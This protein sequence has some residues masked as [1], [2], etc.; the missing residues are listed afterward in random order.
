[1]TPRKST[2]R[3]FTA[4]LLFTFVL[5]ACGGESPE[6]MVASA[7]GYLAKN[8]QKAAVIQLKNALQANPNLG[9]ARFLLGKA[10][11][12]SGNPVAAAVELGK[13]RELKYP[14]DEVTPLFAKSQLMLGQAA[15]VSDEFA[16]VK[17][18]S[19]AGN[20][21]LQTTVGLAFL[22]QGKSDPAK[23]AFEAA[24]AAV[25]DYAPAV[26]GMA[27]LKAGNRDLPGAL[28]LIDAA[29]QKSP[30]L[31]EAWQLKGLLQLAQG[32]ATAATAAY[33]KALE[34][35]P[36]Y[37]PAHFAL[38]SLS[39][40]QGQLEAAGKQIET[41]KSVAAVPQTSFL[42]AQLF[43][44]QKDFKAAQEAIQQYLKFLPDD[45]LGQQLA[46]VIAYE[47]Q[48]YSTAE[49]YLLKV[50][51]KTPELG[52][53]R[54]VLIAT[55]LKSGH[56]E[57]ALAILQPVLGKI[58]K[59]SDMLAL[60]GEVFMQNGDVDKA[61]AHFVKAAALDP[62][63]TAKR[64]SVALSHLA[65]GN[66]GPAQEELEQLAATDTGI[67]ADMGLI[68][69][70][71]KARKYDQALKAIAGLE[72]KQPQ[73]ALVDNLRGSALMA[74]GELANAR[75]SFEQ[76]LAKNPA[77]LPAAVNLA[78]LDLAAKKPDE[79]KKRI[80]A[81]VAKD[82]KNVQALLALAELQAKTGA[83]PDEVA[84]LVSKAVSIAPTE[85]APRL[86]LISLYLATKDNNKALSAA[87]EAM[88]ALPD[89]PEI[90]DAVGRVQQVAGQNNQALATYAKLASLLPNSPQPYLRMAEIQIGAKDAEAAMQSLRRALAVKANSV[91]AQRGIMM[92]D[93]GAGRSA[94]AIAMARQVQ[95][96][97]P[98]EAV[99]YVLEGD[100]HALTKAWKAA[101]VA[102][103]NG[104]QKTGSGDL[105]IKLHAALVASG[106]PAE[107]DAFAASWMKEHASDARFINYLAEEALARKDYAKAG[108]HYR[109]LLELQPNNAAVLNNLAWAL[110][111]AKDPKALEFA[112]KANKLAPDQPPVMDTLGNLLVAQGDAARGVE[113][114]KKAVELAPQNAPI[115]L[116]YAKALVKT[117]KKAE[118]KKELDELAKLGDKFPAHA[119]VTQLSASL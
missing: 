66:V 35:K 97:R 93:L 49:T 18:S 57:K 95:K 6:T 37:L 20:A 81:V 9:E 88:S 118:A 108:N 59:N 72:K 96:Q 32:D 19:A 104:V 2:R 14:E 98:N 77:F 71:L 15:K 51:P 68:A 12:E 80:E 117:G 23:A 78:N 111:Q 28:A 46:G 7:K 74:K 114:L 58:E 26:I 65:K 13:A 33:R 8:D 86:A 41:L 69:S 103:R 70:Y 3:A 42:Q 90:L 94:E 29:L 38:I 55:Y 44:R 100:A 91:E 113:L 21:D 62:G 24:L 61:E 30:A 17:L 73:N 56:P 43:Y 85:P 105:A 89:R 102:Y 11:L 47:L 27:K 67:K 4:S 82:E 107:A 34:V 48:A 76:A 16:K 52:L 87:Q 1:M 101:A 31:F 79:A 45:P 22:A 119:E 84:A 39:M 112:E 106:T 50:L 115:R 92:L 110:A 75:K 36:D 99:G 116:N 54:R 109:R 25:P 5:A 63:N 83:K 64:T 60:A 40:D 10:L 53:A